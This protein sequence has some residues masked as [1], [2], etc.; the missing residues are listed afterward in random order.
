MYIVLSN[1]EPAP[2]YEQIKKQIMEQIVS[3]KLFPGEMLPSIRLLAKELEISVITVKKAYDDLESEGFIV[4]RPGKGSCVAA[5]GA[6]FIREMKLKTMQQ[7]FEQG[8]GVC[9]ELE[10]DEA[11]IM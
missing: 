5:A 11:A 7:F 8:I 6:E 4:T 2:L 9:R 1:S 3:G 10:M